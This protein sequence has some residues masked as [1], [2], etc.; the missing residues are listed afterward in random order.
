VRGERK[1]R[2]E[3]AGGGVGP[4]AGAGPG[5]K[6]VGWACCCFVF[7]L[8]FQILFKFKSFTSFQIQIFNTNFSN[9]FKGFSQPIFSNFLNIF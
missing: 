3:W 1:G 7:F 8:F 9:Y 5:K 4:E 2:W 6:E